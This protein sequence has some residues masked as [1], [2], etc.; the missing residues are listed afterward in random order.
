LAK[1]LW[2]D[3]RA[4]LYELPHASGQCYVVGGPQLALALAC[5]ASGVRRLGPPLAAPAAIAEGGAAGD[6]P[7]APAIGRPRA[8]T[9]DAGLPVPG[10]T[11]HGDSAAPAAPDLRALLLPA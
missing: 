2:N 11:V 5:S 3:A 9:P 8:R 7:D 4:A 1:R 6:S 10:L